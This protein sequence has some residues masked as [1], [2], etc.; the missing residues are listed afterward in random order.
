VVPCLLLLLQQQLHHSL[1]QLLCLGV[2][3][4]WDQLSAR[5]IVPAATGAV[6]AGQEAAAACETANDPRGQLHTFFWLALAYSS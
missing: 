4:L 1:Q 6:V 3:C 5:Q 2:C